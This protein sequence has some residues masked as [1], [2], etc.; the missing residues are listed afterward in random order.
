MFI[1]SIIL[2]ALSAIAL[3]TL[4]ICILQLIAPYVG[5]NLMYNASIEQ[6]EIDIPK[7]GNCAICIRS[8]RYFFERGFLYNMYPTANFEIT[9]LSTGEQIPFHKSFGPINRNIGNITIPI[10]YFYAPD[11]GRYSVTNLSTDSYAKDE[12]IVIRKHLPTG[13][14]VLLI[15]GIVGSSMVLLSG[16]IIASLIL[17]GII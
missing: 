8:Y 7:I 12:V 9:Q 4:I 13:K 2:Y 15:L 10:G 16:I 11:S 14:F 5:W 1:L 3:I 6:N 17:A